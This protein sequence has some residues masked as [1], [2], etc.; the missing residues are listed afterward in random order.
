MTEELVEA[1]TV[2]LRSIAQDENKGGGLLSRDTHR[3][4]GAVRREL[5][6]T[7]KKLSKAVP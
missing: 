6:R 2:L 7:L 5:N 1:I 4:A 3:L